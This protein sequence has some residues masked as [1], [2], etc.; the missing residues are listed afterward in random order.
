MLLSSYLRWLWH[1]VLFKDVVPNVKNHAT[2]CSDTNMNIQCFPRLSFHVWEMCQE[3]T[4][5]TRLIL[6]IVY[7]AYGDV[8]PKRMYVKNVCFCWNQTT[9][10]NMYGQLQTSQGALWMFIPAQ[11]APAEKQDSTTIWGTLKDLFQKKCVVY[12]I[13]PVVWSMAAPA[14]C[15]HIHCMNYS[16]QDAFSS[17]F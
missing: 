2:S 8:L 3:C 4:Q 9:I 6:I 13:K 14:L 12:S 10:K 5:W 11:I 1:N 7:F 15:T 17:Y 16:D